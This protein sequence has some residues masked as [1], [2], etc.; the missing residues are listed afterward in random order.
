[1]P[2]DDEDREMS[3]L[4]R[5]KLDLLKVLISKIL[6]CSD[7]QTRIEVE[8]AKRIVAYSQR[9]FFKH[10]RLYD[11]VFKNAKLNEQKFIKMAL[12]VP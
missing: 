2:S 10:L 4:L 1:M 6:D 9:T 7:I 3:Q 8:H 12:D 11:F 5:R